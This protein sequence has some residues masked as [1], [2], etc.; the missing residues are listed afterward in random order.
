MASSVSSPATTLHIR[1][2]FNA[3]RE[4]VFQ[5]WTDPEKMTAWFCHAKPEMIGK[6]V[7]MDVRPGGRYGFDVSGADGKVFKVRGEYLEIK[8]PGETSVHVVLGNGTGVRRHVGDAGI[9]GLGGEKRVDHDPRTVRKQRCARQA[10]QRLGV[11][12][13]F[14]ATPCGAVK[15]LAIGC[16]N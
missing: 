6:L 2:V 15:G 11:L 1:R 16:E 9:C 7:T 10:Q 4:R 5:A 12:P 8:A 3:P 13:G 14:A